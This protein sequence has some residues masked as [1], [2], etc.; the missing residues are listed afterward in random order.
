MG[1]SI[2]ILEN[3][4]DIE[5]R[6]FQAAADEINQSLR[7]N[8]SRAQQLLNRLIPTWIRSQPEIISL[9][10]E[11]DPTSL[12][13]QFGLTPGQGV[14]VL[15]DIV[16]AVIQATKFK[17][18]KVD[19]KFRG[20]IEIEIQPTDYNNII[21]SPNGLVRYPFAN[22]N[23]LDWLLLKGDTV[24][25]VGHTYTINPGSGRSGDGVMVSGG[26]WRVP[27]Q[28][29]GTADNNFITRAF[30]NRERELS[31]LLQQIFR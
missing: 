2:K 12:N 27:P 3:D 4:R 23:F 19:R 25:V 14:E 26:S 20:G 28:F 17:V 21:S 9:L 22:L 1:L 13:S 31:S 29:S 24:I 16:E 15:D 6:I 8:S 30:M 10:S 18:T 5:R 11:N 7:K